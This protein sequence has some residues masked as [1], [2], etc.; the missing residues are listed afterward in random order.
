MSGEELLRCLERV[1]GSVTPSE[2]AYQLGAS[3][4]VVVES[5]CDLE[6]EGLVEPAKWRAT[7]AG[8]ERVAA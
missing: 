5:L 6:A 1:G 2:L 3:E 4:N 8:R 7:P